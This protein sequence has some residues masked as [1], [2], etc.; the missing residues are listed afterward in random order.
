MPTLTQGQA[1]EKKEKNIYYLH[2]EWSF[3]AST[4]PLKEKEGMRVR[5]VEGKTESERA[6]ERKREKKR[7]GEC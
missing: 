7:D 3:S 1:R 4:A 5:E 6:R 2:Q